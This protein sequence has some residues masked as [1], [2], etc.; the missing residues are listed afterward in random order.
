MSQLRTFVA[1][2]LDGSARQR[3]ERV[4]RQIAKA[5][6]ASFELANPDQVHLTMC[7]L[8]DVDLTDQHKVSQIVKRSVQDIGAFTLDI[9]G[10]GGFPNLE[11]PRV[12]WLGVREPDADVSHLSDAA[13]ERLGSAAY[14]PGLASLNESLVQ[15]FLD[16]RFW[17]DTKPFRPHITI[18]RVRGGKGERKLELPENVLASCEQGL[19]TISVESIKVLSSEGTQN[20]PVYRTISTIDL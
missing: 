6:S 9:H 18:G 11:S 8:G 16:Q 1:I 4:G 19:G 3:V 2:A 20:G 7:F 15:A 5:N 10:L 17:P 12:V 14:C 13:I